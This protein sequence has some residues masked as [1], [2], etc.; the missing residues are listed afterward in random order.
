MKAKYGITDDDIYNFD[1]TGFMMGVISTT[2]QAE[3]ATVIQGV[4]SQG[5][6]VPPFI[7]LAGQY[8]LANWCQEPNLPYDWVIATTENGWTTNEKGLEW[9]KHFD[10]HT[11]ARTKGSHRLLDGEKR[12]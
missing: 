10:K 8:H 11:A 12:R 9:I 6:A 7:I 2:W 1:E 4:N 5:W 3:W